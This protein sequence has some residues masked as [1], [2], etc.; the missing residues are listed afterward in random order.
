MLK[1]CSKKE[2]MLRS[3]TKNLLVENMWV[4]TNDF[5]EGQLHQFHSIL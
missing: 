5:I 3:G 4:N 2:E 1:C